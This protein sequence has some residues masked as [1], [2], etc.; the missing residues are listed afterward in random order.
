M[1]SFRFLA[2]AGLTVFAAAC[3]SSGRLSG[4]AIT[5]LEQS[6]AAQPNDPAVARSLGIA[7]YRSERFAD[8]RPHLDQAVRL[9]P[10]DGT[11]ALY[12]GLTA[13]QQQDLPAAKAA[14]Q[15]Y[16]RY[17]RTSRVRRQLEARLA[18][19]TRQELH[20]AAKTSIAQEQQLSSQQGSPLT[21]A[22]MPL[23]FVGADSSL[24][25]LERGFAEL[26]TTDLSQSS[27]LTVV[28]RARLQALLDEMTLQQSGQTDSTTNLRAGRIIQAGRIVSGQIVQDEQRLRVDA[29][30]LSTQ[31]SEITGGAASENTLEQ[32]FT[33]E[34]AIVFQLFESLGVTLTTAERD[35]IEQRPTRSLQAFLAYSRG[36]ALEDQG[37]YDDAS[38]SYQEAVRIDPAF[39]RASQK[40][41]ETQAAAE[42]ALMSATSIE[43][44]LANTTEGNIANRSSQGDASSGRGGDNSAGNLADGLNPSAAGSSTSAAGGGN[45]GAP[46][47]RDALGA[48]TGAESQP[49]TATV[50]VIVK[51]PRP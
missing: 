13:E 19:L 6:R 35:A 29:A 22:V 26:L 48:G 28:E 23:R 32:L 41:A 47:N 17:G 37:L 42:G 4:D 24:Q 45:N 43:T 10:R 20:V 2:I 39:G 40:S 33:I 49:R 12:L 44:S 14:Y 3:A 30:I 16:V 31:S 7:Y 8:A 21:V 51:L 5:R 11:A 36:L 25:P 38:R 15:S 27:Q 9:D 50:T 46:P 1:R 18:A 34:K